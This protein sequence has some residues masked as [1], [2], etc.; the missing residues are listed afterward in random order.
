VIADQ[1]ASDRHRKMNCLE[2]DLPWDLWDET[3]KRRFPKPKDIFEQI[4]GI[5]YSRRINEERRLAV[6]V[7]RGQYPKGCELCG[8]PA[9]AE[10]GE[11]YDPTRDDG[12]GD[13]PGH[14][15]AHAQCG[16]DRE[17]EMA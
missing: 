9:G 10:M 11:F 1:C 13:Y 7:N 16:L 2:A 12:R 4:F 3:C 5:E 8:E 17:L 15:L 6:L 14:V